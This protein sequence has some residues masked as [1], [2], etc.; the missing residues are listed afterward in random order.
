[1]L[2]VGFSV[3]VSRRA[4]LLKKTLVRKKVRICLEVNEYH[5]NTISKTVNGEHMQ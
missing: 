5:H 1:M 2:G 4:R 3:G